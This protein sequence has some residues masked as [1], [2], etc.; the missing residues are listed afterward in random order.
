MPFKIHKNRYGKR[1]LWK[2]AQGIAE[3]S[4]NFDKIQQLI[5]SITTERITSI[6]NVFNSN[7]NINNIKWTFCVAHTVNHIT[8]HFLSS[9]SLLLSVSLHFSFVLFNSRFAWSLVTK[10][11]WSF[12]DGHWLHHFQININDPQ[13]QNQKLNNTHKC[14]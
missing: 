7:A 8:S 9:T 1:I 4:N 11:F 5:A 13:D 14:I 10:H 2:I 3:N 12:F 6:Q